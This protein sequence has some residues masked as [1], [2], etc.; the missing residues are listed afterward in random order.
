[1]KT[2]KKFTLLM[3]LIFINSFFISLIP[4]GG[5]RIYKIINRTL[6]IPPPDEYL[7]IKNGEGNKSLIFLHGY[8]ASSGSFATWNN[9]SLFSGYY[10]RVVAINYYWDGINPKPSNYIGNDSIFTKDTNISE[11]IDKLYYFINS[12][13]NT[14]TLDFMCHSMGGLVTRGLICK[15]YQNLT[16]NGIYIDDVLTLG[17]PNQGSLAAAYYCGTHP[18]VHLIN[19]LIYLRYFLHT[20]NPLV[21]IIGMYISRHV[22]EVTTQLYQIR[23]NSP[24]YETL[25]VGGDETPYSENITWSTIA[26]NFPYEYM[27]YNEHVGLDFNLIQYDDWERGKNILFVNL[28]VQLFLWWNIGTDGLVSPRSVKLNGA[29][30]YI[31]LFETHDSLLTPDDSR[32]N[33]I[34]NI[35]I[36]DP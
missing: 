4:I 33:F 20:E 28:L 26:G 9:T 27:M 15:Y 34:I 7:E 16:A 6:L 36:N 13:F 23:L 8:G 24:L 22:M 1:M 18:F 12:T 25:M 17:T 31:W 11:I 35:L 29:H 32:R 19:F 3:I 2:N 14:T 10:N 21:S 5:N 30:N